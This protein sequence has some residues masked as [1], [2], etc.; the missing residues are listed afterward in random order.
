V[1]DGKITEI[2]GWRLDADDDDADD[3]PID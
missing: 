1:D 2:G 3:V